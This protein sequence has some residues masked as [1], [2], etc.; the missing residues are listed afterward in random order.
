MKKK[1]RSRKKE[2][3]ISAVTFV[4]LDARQ[5]LNPKNF[6][7]FIIKFVISTYL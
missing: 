7:D 6:Y 5:K 4:E 3:A 1:K 2:V